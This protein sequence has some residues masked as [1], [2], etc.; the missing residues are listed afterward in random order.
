MKEGL[1]KFLMPRELQ[2]LTGLTL[3]SRYVVEGNLSGRHRSPL[4][5]ASTEFADHRA[6][7]PGDDPKRLDWK[8]LGRTDRYFI[9]RAFEQ[10]AR[11]GRAAPARDPGFF[12]PDDERACDAPVAPA[13][14]SRS[15][16]S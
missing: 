10:T 5:G 7:F 12:D 3:Q 9:R 16:S 13:A 6:Y 8:V 4:R 15:A 11:P 14:S 2:K 1:Q